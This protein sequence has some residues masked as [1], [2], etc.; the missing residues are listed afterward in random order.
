M[1]LFS[2][3]DLENLSGIKAHTIRIWE[4]RYSFLK[5]ARTV[6]NIRYYANRE[7]KVLLNAALLNKCGFRVSHIDGMNEKE[8][9]QKI[10]TLTD[11]RSRNEK[12]MNDLIYFM[13]DLDI[14]K[15]EKL[16]DDRILETGIDQT[17]AHLIVPFLDRMGIIWLAD[18]IQ[19][20]QQPLIT[21]IIRQ[22]LL[23]GIEGTMVNTACSKKVL[24]F[25]P[26]GEHQEL[27][28]LC[29][30]YLLKSRVV[31]TLY[32]GANVPVKDVETVCSS[33]EPDYLYTHL[34]PANRRFDVKKFIRQISLILPSVHLIISGQVTQ[35]HIGKL[36]THVHLKKS[37]HEVMEYVTNL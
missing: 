20:A 23:A 2:I 4:H 27:G 13:I 37:A 15:F 14:D 22:K 16:L 31:K 10:R 24:L 32:L 18:H 25:L 19:L 1:N 28:L 3:K 7:L 34:T 26:E 21:N 17:I 6:T 35:T 12:V 36:P 33:K 5:P 11:A 8:I 30:C 9:Q 29:G